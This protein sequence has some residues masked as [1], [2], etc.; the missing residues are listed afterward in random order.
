[1]SPRPTYR[2]VRT[3]AHAS[4]RVAIVN[5]DDS[6]QRAAH[7]AFVAKLMA[8]C[9]RIETMQQAQERRDRSSLRLFRLMKNGAYVCMTKTTRQLLKQKADPNFVP[10]HV[11]QGPTTLGM[12]AARCEPFV[13]E[14]LLQ[15][16]ARVNDRFTT[17]LLPCGN[18]S[19]L[20]ESLAHHVACHSQHH[21][22]SAGSDCRHIRTI[23]CLLKHGAN[24]DA[25]DAEGNT[26]MHLAAQRGM[27][28]AVWRLLKKGADATVCNNANKSVLDE[29]VH[30]CDWYQ[31]SHSSA[32]M[33]RER[34]HS[35]ATR[36]PGD[37]TDS[38][39]DEE[40]V[41]AVETPSP[42]DAS[43]AADIMAA[44]KSLI[45]ELLRLK[46]KPLRV[47][48]AMSQHARLGAESKLGALTPDAM[49]SIMSYLPPH[50]AWHKFYEHVIKKEFVSAASL[51]PVLIEIERSNHS[52]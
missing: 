3:T 19:A 16:G 42:P 15:H 13:V 27:L 51:T 30:Q 17:E 39:S 36:P 50:P 4:S 29:L 7:A 28:S 18:R 14:L 22:D 12:A 44:Y 26:P 47:A 20:H 52:A 37:A 25:Q 8:R 43:L 38:G 45:L 48:V 10:A 33:L 5:L 46:Y 40:L 34:S 24:I 6:G 32:S 41:E 2:C 1:M 9:Q 31:T 11:A 35:P 49:E 21:S 23:E